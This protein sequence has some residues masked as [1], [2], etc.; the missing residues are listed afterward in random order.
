MGKSQAEAV[1]DFVQAPKLFL[2]SRQSLAHKLEGVKEMLRMADVA[3]AFAASDIDA[4]LAAELGITNIMG[5]NKPFIIVADF[6]FEVAVIAEGGQVFAG[7]ID[8]KP[9]ETV[10]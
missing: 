10:N 9:Q 6:P 7:S 3:G 5:V 1:I 4:L 8:E 2:I